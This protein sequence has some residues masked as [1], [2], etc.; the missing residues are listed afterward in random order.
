MEKLTFLFFQ[1]FL[2]LLFLVRHGP[3]N[4]DMKTN[5]GLKPNDRMWI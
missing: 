2:I 3:S 5:F 4:R 1:L